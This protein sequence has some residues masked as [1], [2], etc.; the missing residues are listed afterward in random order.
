M[1]SVDE[2]HIF[3]GGLAGGAGAHNVTFEIVGRPI[4]NFSSL[5]PSMAGYKDE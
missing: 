3:D 5:G 4:T 1:G 2:S